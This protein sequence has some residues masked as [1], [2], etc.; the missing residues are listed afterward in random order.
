MN[1][2]EVV[3]FIVSGNCTRDLWEYLYSESIF[4][5]SSTSTLDL[6]Q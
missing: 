1:E 4:Q 3:V 6:Q 2:F 5:V